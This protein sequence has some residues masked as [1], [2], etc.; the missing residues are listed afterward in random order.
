MIRWKRFKSYLVVERGLTNLTANSYLG[1]L[2]RFYEATKLAMPTKD[3]LVEYLMENF[4]EK[5]MS[6]THTTNT[7]RALEAYEDFI[8]NKVRFDRPRKPNRRIEDWLTEQEIARMFVFTEDVREQTIL[9]L[10]AYTGIRTGELCSLKVK[11]IN[12]EDQTVFI[13]AGKGLKDGRVCIAPI[14][15]NILM[16]YLREHPREPNQTL[17]FSIIGPREGEKMRTGAIRKHVK[18][19]ARRAGLTRRVYPYLFRHS[20]ATNLLLNGADVY[21][22]KEQMRHVFIS[23]TEIYIKSNPQI[24]KNNYQI[25]V[26]RYIWGSVPMP[27]RRPNMAFPGSNSLKFNQ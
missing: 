25:F 14:A 7:M 11:N 4:F 19:V 23:T 12:F 3:D 8:G 24:L 20:L 18:K 26:P 21:S 9:A 10:L 27:R 15:L 2:R 16:E 1:A 17:L 13:K 6:Y 5:G 22:V